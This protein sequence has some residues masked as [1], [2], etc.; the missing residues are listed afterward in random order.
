MGLLIL[1]ILQL[2]NGAIHATIGGVFVV[3]D[4]GVMSYNVYTFFYGV[5]NLVF[6]YGLWTGKKSGW[7][8]TILVYI[9]VI[10]IDV[11]VS[12]DIQLI[13]GV[14]KTAALGEIAISLAL[15]VYLMQP[16][17]REL[18]QQTK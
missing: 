17:I 2:L 6:L 3:L 16:K 12:F 13:P 11:C 1:T 15:L 7:I 10:I 5:L 8:G 14:P 4:I 9:L 18:F